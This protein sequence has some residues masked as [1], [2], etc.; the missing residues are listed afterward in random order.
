MLSLTSWKCKTLSTRK[1]VLIFI[2]DLMSNFHN[3]NSCKMHPYCLNAPCCVCCVSL[4]HVSFT[5]TS[6]I[7]V[8]FSSN[9]FEPKSLTRH[10]SLFTLI[11]N[12][13]NVPSGSLL[14]QPRPSGTSPTIFMSDTDVNTCQCSQ[15]LR[16]LTHITFIHCCNNSP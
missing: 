7:Q 3:L 14:S 11:N 4:G 2:H 8:F 10:Y 6:F 16:G 12:G 1:T 5:Q 9:R 15:D 13:R